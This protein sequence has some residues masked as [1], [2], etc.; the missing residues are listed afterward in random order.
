MMKE[1]WTMK[2]AYVF[3]T[4]MASTFKLSTMILPQLKDGSH[5]AN[6]RAAIPTEQI[7]G[8]PHVAVTRARHPISLQASLT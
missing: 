1:P 2:V 3:A 4:N 5:G 7:R 8:Q 6:G